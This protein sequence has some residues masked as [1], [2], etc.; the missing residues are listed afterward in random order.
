MNHKM[1]ANIL[2]Y[3]NIMIANILYES[4]NDGQYII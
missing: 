2:Y 3:Y 1:I 4:Y